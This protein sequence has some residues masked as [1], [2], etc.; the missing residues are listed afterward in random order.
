GHKKIRLKIPDGALPWSPKFME[1]YEAAM[2]IA[3][4]A[5]SIGAS[6]TTPGTVNAAL[7]SYYRSIA[8]VSGLAE[9]TQRSR[10]AILEAFRNDHGDKRIALIHSKAMQNIVNG[11]TPAAARNFKKAMRGFVDHCLANNLI[12]ADPLAGLKLVKLKSKGHHPWE[13]D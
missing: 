2:S 12:K 9:S 4:D 3:P 11:K 7:I 1:V 8:F 6:R 13:S 5:P 10:R